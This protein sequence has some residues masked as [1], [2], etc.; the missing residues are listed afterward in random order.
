VR[1]GILTPGEWATVDPAL[2]VQLAADTQALVDE[3]GEEAVAQDVER[4]R[5]DLSMAYGIV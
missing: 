2:Q 1:L 5:A 3:Y 4:H